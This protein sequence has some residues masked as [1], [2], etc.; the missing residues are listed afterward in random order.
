MGKHLFCCKK[1]TVLLVLAL[2]IA[3]CSCGSDGS[4]TTADKSEQGAVLKGN[5]ASV[6][7]ASMEVEDVG[8]LAVSI[9]ELT[10]TTDQQGNF[11][12][13]NIPTGDHVV[14][15]EN[16]PAANL[17]AQAEAD[18]S[19]EYSLVVKE[20]ETITLRDIEIN[21]DEVV[22]EHTGTWSGTAGSDDPSSDGQ[23]AFTMYIVANGNSITGTGRLLGGSDNSVWDVTGIETGTEISG[24]FNL[25]SSDSE[26]ATGGTFEGT[27]SGNTIS[28]TFVEVNP[29]A[30]CGDPEQGSFYLEK[31]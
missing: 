11:Q 3:I 10:T 13:D 17:T 21:G 12:I 22:T 25:V 8:G 14:I 4:D 6:T 16:V 1:V 9:G 26:C 24:E 27:F 29:P 30:G 31:E 28:A 23:L 15:F 5:V 2:S 19:A 20:P 18:V 7:T